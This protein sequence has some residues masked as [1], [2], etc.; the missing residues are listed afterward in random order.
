MSLVRRLASICLPLVLLLLPGFGRA[1]VARVFNHEG[2]LLGDE[3]LPLEGSF[4]FVF[5]LYDASDGPLEDALWEETHDVEVVL[6]YYSLLLGTQGAGFSLQDFVESER[7]YLGITVN[8]GPELAPRQPLSA[9]PYALVAEDVSGH[10][11]PRS[12]SVGGDLVIDEGGSWVGAFGDI[13]TE[14]SIEALGDITSHGQ[15][16]MTTPDGDLFV[17]H[18]GTEGIVG[19]SGGDL[20]LIPLGGD[21]RVDDRLQV[22]QELSVG[23]FPDRA[24]LQADALAL[25][26]GG[27]LLTP[28]LRLEDSALVVAGVGDAEA[29]R[30]VRIDSRLQVVGAAE[31]GGRLG[32]LGAPDHGDVSLL[33]RSGDLEIITRAG[34]TQTVFVT[35]SGDGVANLEVEGTATLGEGLVLAEGTVLAVPGASEGSLGQVGIGTNNPE[36]QLQITSSTGLAAVRLDTLD[37]GGSS[38]WDI[39]AM[40]DGRLV[41]RDVQANQS[42]V[43]FDPSGDV[44][45]LGGDLLLN[46][47]HLISVDGLQFA[48]PGGPIEGIR[49]GGTGAHESGIYVSADKDGSGNAD[50]AMWFNSD[51]GF[52]WANNYNDNDLDY[53]MQLATG[54]RLHVPGG[55]GLGTAAAPT[56]LLHAATLEPVG[57]VGLLRL[58]NAGQNN[59]EIISFGDSHP[60]R[61]GW[62]QL[63]GWNRDRPPARRALPPPG[64]RSGPPRPPACANS[65]AVAQATGAGPRKGCAYTA[66][67]GAN[68]A[69]LTSA[70][71]V[72]APLGIRTRCTASGPAGA[73]STPQSSEKRSGCPT[74]VPW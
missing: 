31:V 20:H 44:Q 14:G 13:F 24:V 34:A 72:A 6:G 33:T 36:Q 11:H 56:H 9:T 19:T 7:L 4:Q 12:V 16:R 69:P 57:P 29:S 40:A 8:G 49:W 66:R 64:T 25:P 26:S 61:G 59:F 63:G 74:K 39:L 68:G 67:D 18:D 71:S 53:V 22:E 37:D 45:V 32:L 46:N 50:G 60:S 47:N 17:Q 42:R 30:Q 3:G 21:V 65:A 5:R 15:L 28:G 38:T 51:Q 43:T 62:V 1:D 35:G 73:S 55:L 10:I 58:E 54:G 2:L 41:F 23:I 48:D 70:R 27:G 52:A